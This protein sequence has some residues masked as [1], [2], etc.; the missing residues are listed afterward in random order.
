MR[1]QEN[2]AARGEQAAINEATRFAVRLQRRR[3]QKK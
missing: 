2:F 1:K 3:L